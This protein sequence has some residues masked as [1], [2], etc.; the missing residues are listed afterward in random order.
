MFLQKLIKRTKRSK[1]Q[2]LIDIVKIQSVIRGYLTRKKL[3]KS[4]DNMTIEIIDKMIDYYND[5]I[6]FNSQLNDMLSKKKIRN[7]NFPSEISENIVKYGIYKKYNVMGCWDTSRG[8][9]DLLKLKIEVK[10]F[11][12]NG[13]SSFGPTEKWDWIY[14]IDCR[15]VF[16]KNFKIYEIRL[17]NNHSIWKNIKI[18]A[19][20]T[21]HDQCCQKRRPHLAF[22]NI[23]EQIKA[24]CNLIFDGNISEL[25]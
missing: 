11:S 18:N 20:Q 14:F 24:H 19:K 10:G 15:D 17:S 21:M 8:D 16:H 13:P 12:S 4:K 1:Y 6:T 5:K 3:R 2:I 25:Y 7:E 9:L 23:Y 22:A